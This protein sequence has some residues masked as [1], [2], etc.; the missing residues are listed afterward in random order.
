[1]V[2]IKGE[3][4]ESE[5]A[6]AGGE[7]DGTGSL[8]GEDG[9]AGIGDREGERGE[10]DMVEVALEAG[11]EG[12]GGVAQAEPLEFAG[13]VGCRKSELGAQGLPGVGNHGPGGEF[14]FSGAKG[15]EG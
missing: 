8:D 9:A 5:F 6:R 14:E 7:L 2:E 10:G 12:E 15:E 13:E 3:G 11:G 1:A 4:I